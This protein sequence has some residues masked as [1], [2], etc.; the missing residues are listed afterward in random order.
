MIDIPLASINVEETT[1]R[2]GRDVTSTLRGTPMRGV[3]GSISTT[4][5]SSDKRG[6]FL[7]V[8]SVLRD[9]VRPDQ[10]IGDPQEYFAVLD[11]PVSL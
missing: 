9:L 5:S 7:E 11:E 6:S 1:E 2:R 8:H 4:D 3:R 10:A